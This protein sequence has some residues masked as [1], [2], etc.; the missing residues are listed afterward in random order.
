MASKKKVK[1][2]KKGLL[3]SLRKKLEER[4]KA[5]HGLF[6]T[7]PVLDALEPKNKDK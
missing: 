6:G 4:K 2:N 3:A 5:M 7:K 1:L